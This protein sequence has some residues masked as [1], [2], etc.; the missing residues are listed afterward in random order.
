ML[1]RQL[2]QLNVSRLKWLIICCLVRL[3][4]AYPQEP[5]QT[6]VE[7]AIWRDPGEH[8]RSDVFGVKSAGCGD[9][10]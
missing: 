6:T 8:C 5:P 7:P 3:E 2:H 1:D 9:G 4:W 10:W